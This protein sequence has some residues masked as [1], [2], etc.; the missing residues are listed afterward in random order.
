MKR[1]TDMDSEFLKEETAKG[2]R[3]F[4]VLGGW[5]V[6]VVVVIWWLTG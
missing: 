1:S 5:I 3:F 4:I 2:R 6:F